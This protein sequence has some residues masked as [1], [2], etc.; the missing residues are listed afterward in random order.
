MTDRPTDSDHRAEWFA[1]ALVVFVGVV[2]FAFYM[3]SA[4]TTVPPVVAT[5]AAPRMGI[6][7]PNHTGC[8]ER[9]SLDRLT[10]LLASGD[11]LASA[12]YVS[13]RRNGCV[14]LTPGLRVHVEHAGV[15]ATLI[16]LPGEP[17]PIWVANPAVRAIDEWAAEPRAGRPVDNLPRAHELRP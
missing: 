5:S 17:T 13:D 10:S 15:S 1:P 3:G 6:T 4:S 12:R 14:L 8:I 7:Q 11:I 9:D 16:R 2:A